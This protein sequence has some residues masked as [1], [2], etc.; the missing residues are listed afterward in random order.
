M[1]RKYYT[2]KNLMEE[3]PALKTFSEKNISDCISEVLTI[4]DEWAP[5][6]KS[7]FISNANAFSL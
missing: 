3:I 4:V 6:K 5:K 7:Y 2:F 1:K